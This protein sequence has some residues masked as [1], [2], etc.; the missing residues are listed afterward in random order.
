MLSYRFDKY[1][2]K[3]FHPRKTTYEIKRGSGS[4]DDNELFG[5][6]DMSPFHAIPQ[7]SLVVFWCEN[8][9]SFIRSCDAF[10][11][12]SLPLLLNVLICSDLSFP[13]KF[14]L[15]SRSLQDLALTT[16]QLFLFSLLRV[17]R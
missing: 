8:G 5:S 17:N 2:K 12:K 4:W 11:K 10:F 16:N 3:Y 14:A 13:M 1:P 6:T 9:G 7:T 15:F